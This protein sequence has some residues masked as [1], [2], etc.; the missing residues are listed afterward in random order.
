[1]ALL[2]SSIILYW[3]N[4][5]LFILFGGKQVTC[6]GNFDTCVFLAQLYYGVPT[7]SRNRGT[8]EVGGP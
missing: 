8:V 1:M 7:L 3:I 2:E 6:A 4:G 5:D